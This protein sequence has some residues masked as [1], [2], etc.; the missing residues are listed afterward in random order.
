MSSPTNPAPED[1]FLVVLVALLG[2]ERENHK[3]FSVDK[4]IMR[5]I[6]ENG[7]K[8]NEMPELQLTHAEDRLEITVK[9]EKVEDDD[10]E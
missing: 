10:T 4:N 8:R 7:I 3:P 6:Y 9:M 5:T 1:L 2:Y